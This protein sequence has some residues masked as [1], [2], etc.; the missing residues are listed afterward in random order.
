MGSV[1]GTGWG[2]VVLFAG[3]AGLGCE[4]IEWPSRR[5]AGHGGGAAAAAMA[6]VSG[7]TRSGVA[8]AT[9]SGVAGA[10][11]S[12]VAGADPG[13]AGGGIAGA[14]GPAG[15]GGGPGS[16]ARPGLRHH[17]GAVCRT[18]IWRRRRPGS[19]TSV[20]A[21]SVPSATGR[22]FCRAT[23]GGWPR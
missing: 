20:A 2:L 5:Q 10:T 13:A 12:G 3:V 16:D 1:R 4:G 6:G 14:G 23:G 8:G 15:Q 19:A 22:S 18:C 21:P 11:G 17:A 7:S 9:G